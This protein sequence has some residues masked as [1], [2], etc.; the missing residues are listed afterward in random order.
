MVDGT[1]R[2]GAR[3]ARY[4]V[5]REPGQVAAMLVAALFVLAGVLDVGPGLMDNLVHLGFGIVGLGLAHGSRGAHAYL[6][7]GGMAYVLLWQFGTV[8]DPSIVPFNTD[9]VA[10]HMLLVVSMIGLA[11][12]T[13]GRT[14]VRT[15]APVVVEQHV[16]PV[17]YV[18]LRAVPS[19]PP[20]RAD[21]RTPPRVAEV[22]RK[23]AVLACRI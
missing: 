21:R 9:D 11:M 4:G 17:R 3:M 20:G 2:K 5:R 6:I 14:P 12:L 19:R 16:P 13:G 22:R 8:V 1:M 10:V 18:R 7:G 23:L 15:D